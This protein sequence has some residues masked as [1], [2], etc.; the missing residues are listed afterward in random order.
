M[1]ILKQLLETLVERGGSDLHITA[2]SPPRIRLHGQLIDTEY[3]PLSPDD[4]KS[5]VYGVL[6]TDQIARFEKNLELDLSFG[7]PEVGRFRTN[8]FI[9]RGAV[10]G[11]LRVVP[12]KIRGFEDIGMPR[13]QCE[14][15]CNLPKGLIL[16]TGATG[17]GKSTSL[18]AM[19]NHI[20]N[21][22]PGAHRH[23]RRP[24]RVRLQEQQGADQ[25]A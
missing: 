3:E 17:S 1:L 2:G 4:T 13:D 11:V 15:L 24:H 14:E 9:Q 5:I 22:R 21:T 10:A 19:M 7:I 18:A 16:V 8:V 6:S 23:H 12:E 20:N 25:P